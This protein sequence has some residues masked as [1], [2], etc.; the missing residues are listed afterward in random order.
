MPCGPASIKIWPRSD[1]TF[2]YLTARIGHRVVRGE[3]FSDAE[4]SVG[5][6]SMEDD[7]H[8]LI[9]QHRLSGDGCLLLDCA[10]ECRDTTGER[11]PD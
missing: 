9:F 11:L 5:R 3:H 10:A 2:L 4:K 7:D 1:T 8:F 6:Y